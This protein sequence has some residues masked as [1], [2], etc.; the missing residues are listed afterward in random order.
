MSD[1]W[2]KTSNDPVSLR[3]ALDQCDRRRKRAESQN[4]ELRA[5]LDGMREDLNEALDWVEEGESVLIPML[6]MHG[7][8]TVPLV[9]FD[10]LVSEVRRLGLVDRLDH[11]RWRPVDV[12]MPEPVGA[13]E[14]RS[15]NRYKFRW[16]D[17]ESEQALDMDLHDASIREFLHHI[18]ATHWRPKARGPDELPEG[19]DDA[20]IM[21]TLTNREEE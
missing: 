18:G 3:A 1:S 6:R 12:E 14:H 8:E 13:T 15:V 5:K 19:Y 17:G 20:R 9:H 4:A 10:M 2:W 21:G 16:W 11:E 7:V